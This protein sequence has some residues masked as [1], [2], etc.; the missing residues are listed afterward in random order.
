LSVGL[1][2]RQYLMMI[3]CKGDHQPLQQPH[4]IIKEHKD[5]N[6]HFSNLIRGHT[7]FM[8]K[9]DSHHKCLAIKCM[10]VWHMDVCL[11]P[12]ICPLPIG[13]TRQQGRGSFIQISMSNK[14][15]HYV[16]VELCILVTC[17]RSGTMVIETKTWYKI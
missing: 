1:C 7:P 9:Q 4:D 2:S 3:L 12:C 16:G 6:L 11:F 15:G 13:Q 10:Y 8:V 14:W 17:A 5:S